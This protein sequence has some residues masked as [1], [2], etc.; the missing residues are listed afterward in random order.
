M[1][2]ISDQ[3]EIFKPFLD[4]PDLN[5]H[6]FVQVIVCL[7]GNKRESRGTQV[8]EMLQNTKLANQESD[9]LAELISYLVSQMG[10]LERQQLDSDEFM[11]VKAVLI[12]FAK[13]IKQD[14]SLYIKLNSAYMHV[15]ELSL[16]GKLAYIFGGYSGQVMF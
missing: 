7:S 16:E 14:P 10:P 11:M 1:N 13:V 4:S 6:R 8:I 3:I 15:A 2:D 5:V 9:L 12:L